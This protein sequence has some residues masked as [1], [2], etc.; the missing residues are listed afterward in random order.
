MN[1]LKNYPGL[2]RTVLLVIMLCAFTSLVNN[3]QG[4][5]ITK[6]YEELNLKFNS[7]D[8]KK[9]EKAIK[10]LNDADVIMNEA[11]QMYSMLEQSEKNLAMSSEYKKAFKK[12]MSASDNYK[13]GHT[14][15]FKVFNFRLL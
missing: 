13:D 10:T 7:S 11:N 14:I 12:L 6:Y 9:F 15:I 8:K 3:A 1:N 2:V 5:E 4:Y